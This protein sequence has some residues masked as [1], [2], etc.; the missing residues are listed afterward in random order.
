MRSISVLIL[1]PETP[2]R[3]NNTGSWLDRLTAL[4]SG[5]EV[6][7]R[8]PAHSSRP[9]RIAVKAETILPP[10]DPQAPWL[11]QLGELPLLA[12]SI[13]IAIAPHA[14]MASHLVILSC[15]ALQSLALANSLSQFSGVNSLQTVAIEFTYC[16]MKLLADPFGRQVAGRLIA[17]SERSGIDLYAIAHGPAASALLRKEGFR[18]YTDLFPSAR[19][20]GHYG[21]RTSISET[22]SLDA[23]ELE[24]ENAAERVVELIASNESM[25][26]RLEINAEAATSIKWVGLL[27]EMVLSGVDLNVRQPLDERLAEQL[28]MAF[29]ASRVLSLA[30][31]DSKADL[32]GRNVW[33]DR[34]W[35]QQTAPAAWLDRLVRKEHDRLGYAVKNLQMAHK[36]LRIDNR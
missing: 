7:T 19:I 24:S 11:E 34:T 26:M 16:A 28:D 13:N 8:P 31:A 21:D 3:S 36:P 5:S 9:A 22:V 32:N 12:S 23:K 10:P 15:S 27:E 2:S 18:L 6:V 4:S 30:G 25:P 33:T 14:G 17:T 20:F 35:R 29:A 1:S